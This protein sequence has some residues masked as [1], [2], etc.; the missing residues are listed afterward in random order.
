MRSIQLLLN[1]GTRLRTRVAVTPRE[2]A[3][4]LLGCQ[5]LDS[6]EALLIPEARSIHTFG[7]RFPIVAAWLDAEHRVLGTRRL[8]PGR[9]A[10]GVRGARHVL[11]C[12]DGTA[13]ELG[14]VLEADDD[15]W[16]GR[17]P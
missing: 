13:I 11:E 14:Q 6:G 4:G 15:S 5:G 1:D 3:R 9:I 2:R 7:M 17:D 8:E 10:W 16:V 12:A